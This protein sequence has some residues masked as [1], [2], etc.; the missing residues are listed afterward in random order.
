RMDERRRRLGQHVLVTGRIGEQNLVHAVELRSGLG[1]GATVLAGNQY[2]YFRPERFSG[3][4]RLGGRV[5]EG[6]VVVLGNEEG[7]HGNGA[8]MSASSWKYDWRMAAVH[9]PCSATRASDYPHFVLEPLD[10]LAHRLH[11]DARLAPCRLGGLEHVEPWR[12]VDG[13]SV[14]RL[15]VDRLLLGFHDVGEA[16]ITRLVEA[17]IGGHNRRAL[18]LYRLQAAVDLARDQNAVALY[19]HFRREGALRPSG[20]RRQHLAGL[21]AIVIDR[22]LAHD[23]EPRLLLLDD[24]LEDFGDGERLEHLVRLHQDAAIGSHREPRADRFSGLRRANRH[25]DDFGCLTL[26]LEPERF[27]DGNLVEGI[28]GH[29]DVRQLDAAAVGLDTNFDVEVDD[30]FYGHQDLHG[31]SLSCRQRRPQ[32]PGKTAAT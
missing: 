30:P 17:Q 8:I 12:D 14:R 2:M 9:A 11:L 19:H 21:I 29:F 4:Q 18:E 5:L 24:G 7:G 23:D 3:A 26:L 27:L 22:L 13:V 28:H 32:P 31:N 10:Q 15:L 20:E 1:D 16:R 6:F 25:A